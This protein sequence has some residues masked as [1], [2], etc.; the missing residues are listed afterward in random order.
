MRKQKKAK[1]IGLTIRFDASIHRKVTELAALENR[2][3]NKQ[4]ELFV[5]QGLNES[6]QKAEV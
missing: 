3:F 4:V 6:R 2:S 1:K 5:T